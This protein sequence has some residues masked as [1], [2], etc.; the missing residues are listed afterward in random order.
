MLDAKVLPKG[1]AVTSLRQLEMADMLV[2]MVLPSW[3]P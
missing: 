3:L 2:V 1:P